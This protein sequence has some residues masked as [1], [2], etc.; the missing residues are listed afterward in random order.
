MVGR[1]RRESQVFRTSVYTLVMH[2]LSFHFIWLSLEW[3]YHTLKCALLRTDVWQSMILIFIALFLCANGCKPNYHSHSHL[4][5]VS[6]LELDWCSLTVL[7]EIDKLAIT[8][9]PWLEVTRFRVTAASR[10]KPSRQESELIN[11]SM[12]ITP[13][14]GGK[15]MRGKVPSLMV[16]SADMCEKVFDSETN[17]ASRANL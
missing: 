8:S 1:E 2:F 9:D 13:F 7:L 4:Q 16:S 12:H 3:I 17:Y 5:P 14:H 11:E 10:A 6:A 15:V